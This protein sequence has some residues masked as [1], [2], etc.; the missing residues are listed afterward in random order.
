MTRRGKK[1]MTKLT[2]GI[3]VAFL[4]M[5]ILVI[6]I[7]FMDSKNNDTE[8]KKTVQNT[9][10]YTEDIEDFSIVT[11][12]GDLLFPK[13][14][15]EYI[16]VEVKKEDDREVVEFWVEFK[17]KEKVHIFDILFGG[18]G[19]KVGTIEISE[20]EEIEVFIKSYSYDLDA[21]WS[22]EDK[23][24]LAAIEYDVNYLLENMKNLDNYTV[25][26]D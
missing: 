17:D 26:R 15:K 18:E 11:S 22:D 19:Y 12:Y 2:W 23:K 7:A 9:E 14:W 8:S 21:S 4:M 16:V 6:T 25:I 3:I 20:S 24:I 1:K 13:V 5:I 10:L